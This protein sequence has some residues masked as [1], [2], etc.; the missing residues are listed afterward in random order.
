MN[1]ISM[2]IFQPQNRT[3]NSPGIADLI[4]FSHG[5]RLRTTPRIRF[6]WQKDNPIQGAL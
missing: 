4:N 6:R 5:P 1:G 3:N 2:M